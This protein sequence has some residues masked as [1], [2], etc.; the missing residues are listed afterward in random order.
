MSEKAKYICPLCG[1]HFDCP[2]SVDCLDDGTKLVRCPDCALK[3]E[4]LPSG[5]V[6]A[7]APDRKE[8]L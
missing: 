1:A 2:I 5:R 3:Y 8:A 7:H 6:F 4:V